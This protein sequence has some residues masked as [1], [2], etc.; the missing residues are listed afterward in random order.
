MLQERN[1]LKQKLRNS[2]FFLFFFVALN[3]IVA[4]LPPL[5][6]T[7]YIMQ[8]VTDLLLFIL[9]LY[10]KEITNKR[11]LAGMLVISYFCN[12]LTL[13]DYLQGTNLIYDYYPFLMY[14]LYWGCFTTLA[15][16][17]VHTLYRQNQIRRLIYG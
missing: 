9:V 17:I 1:L 16:S 11:Q 10:T 5:G 6:E 15:F 2:S 8:G 14:H 4:H 13:E 7:W 3:A 12:G